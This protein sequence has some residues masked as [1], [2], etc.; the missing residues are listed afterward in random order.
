VIERDSLSAIYR[1]EL[2]NC[3]SSKE[4]YIRG[5][6]KGSNVRNFLVFLGKI[7][8]KLKFP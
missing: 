7:E 4:K 6:T 8:E 1:L 3:V 5:E 2:A